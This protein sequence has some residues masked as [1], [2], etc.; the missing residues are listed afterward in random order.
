MRWTVARGPSGMGQPECGADFARASAAK[1]WNAWAE[2][3]WPPP[4]RRRVG[5]AIVRNFYGD[6]RLH[7]RLMRV[8][9][10]RLGHA[11]A[12]LAEQAKIDIA[13]G[14]ATRLALDAIE[15]GLA[16]TLTQDQAIDEIEAD[17][18]RVAAAAHETLRQAGLA[19]DAVDA[20]YLTGGMTGLTPLTQ[21]LAARCPAAQLIRGDRFA[22]VAQGPGLHA[23]RLFAPLQHG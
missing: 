5:K 17:L 22:S 1:R 3:R 6:T 11:L 19:P 7:E 8:L 23:Q 10:L 21:R 15:P 20:L 14:G 2:R 13:D 9:T 18:A 4:R 16:V 12:A